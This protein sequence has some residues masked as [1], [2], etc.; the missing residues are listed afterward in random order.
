[1]H[2]L[3]CGKDDKLNQSIAVAKVTLEGQI[4]EGNA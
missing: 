4:V 3:D 1:M 2:D